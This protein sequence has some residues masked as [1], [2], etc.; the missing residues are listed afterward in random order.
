MVQNIIISC[1]Y[2]A[3][4]TCNLNFIKVNS[5][6]CPL[7]HGKD[8]E[9]QKRFYTVRNSLETLLEMHCFLQMKALNQMKSTCLNKKT[10]IFIM[11]RYF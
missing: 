3:E 2:L 4:F 1:T 9:K 11:I 6:S 7:F 10:R 5:L 8:T